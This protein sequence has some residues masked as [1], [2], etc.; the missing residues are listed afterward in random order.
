MKYYFIFLFTLFNCLSVF[1][2]NSGYK[3]E[4]LGHRTSYESGYYYT[5][6]GEKFSGFIKW[7]CSGWSREIGANYILFKSAAGE[8]K[9]RL[10]TNDIK[11]FVI[12][13]DSFAI[14]KSIVRGIAKYDKDFARVVSTGS[15]TLYSHCEE[16]KA[17]GYT[18]TGIECFY[19]IRKNDSL[20]RL[21]R[22]DFQD[23]VEFLFG[24][25]KVIMNQINNGSL[26]F[27][28]IEQIVAEYNTWKVNQ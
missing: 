9:V 22:K 1:S 19:F 28:N 6:S 12:G 16:T 5:H 10:T 8:K 21:K 11:A 4:P 2:Q 15:L 25:N 17:G 26:T 18:S 24:D 13:K 14:I 3:Y 7:E 23:S 20:Y 27:D